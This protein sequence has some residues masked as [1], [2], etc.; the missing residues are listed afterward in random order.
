MSR[1]ALAL[2]QMLRDLHADRSGYARLRELLEAQF[3]AALRHRAES[4][5]ELAEDIVALVG[6]IEARRQQRGSLLVRLLGPD[7]KPS[8]EALLQR[9]PAATG[10][11]FT[12]AWQGL[13]QQVRE[14]K[15]LN[16]RNCQLITDQ[17]GLMQRV[18]G[19]E[20]PGYAER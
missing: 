17:H 11:T 16:L 3:Q 4:L 5:I 6:E 2:A 20:E 14:C 7:S 10:Q 12:V 9:L 19:A 15:R 8:I 1:P 13:E 18:L